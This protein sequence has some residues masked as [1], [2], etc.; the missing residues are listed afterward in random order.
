MNDVAPAPP[1]F[2]A[3]PILDLARAEAGP[4]AERALA[5]ELRQAA[6]DVGFFYVVG[7]G[8]P[9]SCR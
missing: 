7:H 9:Q 6:I 8:V 5:A 4:E 1:D 2:I 3:I